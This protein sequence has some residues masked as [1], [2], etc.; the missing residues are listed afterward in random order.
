MIYHTICTHCIHYEYDVETETK[1]CAAFPAGIP[2]EII[3]KGFDH[4]QPYPGD[5]GIQFSP[6][7][8]VDPKWID[9]YIARF[10]AKE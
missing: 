3:R 4:R 7:E 6:D 9:E 5:E 8:G 1:A 2:D 10:Q